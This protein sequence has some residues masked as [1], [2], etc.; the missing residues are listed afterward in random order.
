VVVLAA[1]TGVIASSLIVFRRAQE[2]DHERSPPQHRSDDSMTTAL[3]DRMS[4][5]DAT[6]DASP[7]A[8]PA[9][10]A[11]RPREHSVPS[12]RDVM[13]AWER[14]MLTRETYGELF[15]ELNLSESEIERFVQL[16][17]QLRYG[18]EQKR[19]SEE[20]SAQRPSLTDQVRAVQGELLALLGHERFLKYEEYG[21]TL[22][23][24]SEVASFNA[25]LRGTGLPPLN[26]EQEQQLLQAFAEERLAMPPPRT[27]DDRAALVIERNEATALYRSRV[28]E[29]SQNILS[30]QQLA[31]L[32]GKYERSGDRSSGRVSGPAG[33]QNARQPRS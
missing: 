31:V 24:R 5:A 18:F 19:D 23:M 22:G 26:A 21:R 17:D 2:A 10:S 3:P 12:P 4:S 6:A 13:S 7:A 11:S 14:A 28:V 15:K 29:R 25:E 27:S 1:F 9:A 32:R 16:V 8:P 30:E 33:E 20:P